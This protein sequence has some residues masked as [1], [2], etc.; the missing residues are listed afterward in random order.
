[1]SPHA[2]V[3]LEKEQSWRESR[4]CVLPMCTWARML[5]ALLRSETRAGGFCCRGAGGSPTSLG[6]GSIPPLLFLILPLCRVT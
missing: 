3:M 5:P 1:M 6:S 4:K 2:L